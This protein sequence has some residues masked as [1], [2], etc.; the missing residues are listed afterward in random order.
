VFTS[1]LLRIYS[2]KAP[3]AASFGKRRRRAGVLN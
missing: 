3:T 1:Y 2:G